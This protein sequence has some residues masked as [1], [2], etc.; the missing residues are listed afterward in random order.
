[1]AT[2]LELEEKLAKLNTAWEAALKAQEYS[3]MANQSLKR[4]DFGALERAIEKLERRIAIAKTG[5]GLSHSQV[6]FGGYR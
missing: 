2:L 3:G 4:V 6:V 5:G 1:M